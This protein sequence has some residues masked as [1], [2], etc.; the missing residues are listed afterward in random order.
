[1]SGRLTVTCGPMFAGKST[2]LQSDIELFAPPYR[3]FKPELDTREHGR[4]VL[5]NGSYIEAIEVD[6]SNGS[7][8]PYITEDVKTVFVDEVQF[9][10]AWL[11]REIRYLVFERN[12]DVHVYG[13]DLDYKGRAWPRMEQL[14]PMA[15]EIHKL[16]AVCQVCGKFASKTVRISPPEEYENQVLIGAADLYEPRCNLD[17]AEH[18]HDEDITD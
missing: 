9:F 17:F 16:K 14:L 15:D 18:F 12:I 4:I 3:I 2:A 13:L 10:G 1:M 11:T 5:H 8:L 7:L 6:S